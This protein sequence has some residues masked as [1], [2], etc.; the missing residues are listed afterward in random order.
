MTIRR[1]AL[2]LSILFLFIPLSTAH[3]A[4]S[5]H[6]LTKEKGLKPIPVKVKREIALPKG[7]HEGLYLD[8][9][10][11]WVANGSGGD[12]WIVDLRSGVIT[13]RIRSVS[14]FTEAVTKGPDGKF[15][16]TDWNEKKLYGAL[17]AED[18]FTAEVVKSFEPAHPAGVIWN[19]VSFFVLT[20]TRGPLGTKFHLLKLDSACNMLAKVI[21]NTIQE[22]SQL[23]WDGVNLWISSWYDKRVYRVDVDSWKITGFFSSPTVRTTGILCDGSS[24]WVTGTASGL[25]ELEVAM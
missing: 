18:G 13:G 22:P 6:K 24:F 7:Y 25:Y 15:Y 11:M 20:W 8:G 5:V 21:I 4:I 2:L 17:R 10:D 16:I 1:K 23:A 12:T 3:S 19:G 14:G 9:K